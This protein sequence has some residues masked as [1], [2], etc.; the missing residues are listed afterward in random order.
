VMLATCE[1]AAGRR[2]EGD[3][4]VGVAR[5][6][7]GAGVP[8]VVASLWPVDDDLQTLV[9]GFHKALRSGRDAASA[10]QAGQLAILQE[11]GRTAP[12]RSW[13]GFIALGGMSPRPASRS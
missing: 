11:R 4:A 7:L 5:A 2:L 9:V 12:V 3:G 8:S 13:G 10:L 6:F 1:G